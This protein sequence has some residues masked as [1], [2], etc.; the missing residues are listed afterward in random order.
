EDAASIRV[1][2]IDERLELAIVREEPRGRDASGRLRRLDEERRHA[3]RDAVARE[4]APLVPRI[5][6]PELAPGAVAEANDRAHELIVGHARLACRTFAA[7]ALLVERHAKILLEALVIAAEHVG[8][9]PSRSAVSCRPRET[10]ERRSDHRVAA[11]VRLEREA[12]RDLPAR[13]RRIV[14]EAPRQDVRETLAHD[15]ERVEDALPL[16]VAADG[17]ERFLDRFAHEDP[18]EPDVV[19]L[20]KGARV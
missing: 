15:G 18:V 12:K 7:F 9:A 8:E 2:G 10:L 1:L 4:A 20:R 19:D 16:L 14:R 5:E 13:F 3:S 6:L 11:H 17:L